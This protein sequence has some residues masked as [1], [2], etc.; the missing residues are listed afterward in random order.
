MR[1]AIFGAGG[2]GCYVGAR[3]LAGGHEVVFIARGRSLEALR[4]RGLRCYSVQGDL[5]LPRVRV[6]DNPHD[7]GAVDA[8][9]LT[10]KL[11]DLDAAAVEFGPLLGPDTLVVPLQN[12]I[13]ASDR[14]TNA[15][16]A[17]CVLKGLVHVVSHLVEPGVVQHSSPFC[18]LVLGELDGRSSPRCEALA[19]TLANCGFD[20]RTS[21]A[22]DAELWRKFTRLAAFS[23]VAC[24]ARADLGTLLAN[25]ALA[26]L[27]SDAM[28]EVAVVARAR[29]IPLPADV[30]QA[31]L[32]EMA[33]YPGKARPSMLEDLEAGRRLEVASLSGAVVRL[34]RLHGV[35]TPIHDVAWRALQ[36][37]ESGRP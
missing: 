9:I 19:R 7:A 25:P 12:G 23:A 36:V 22:I 13:D 6:T 33:G 3:L 15:I 20:A 35:A 4:E 32:D 31:S 1:I 2:V 16:G 14:L 10:V 26:A 24:L 27:L 8:V 21:P 37:H 5:H 29:G 30:V 34:G 17:A 18:R 28:T 11:Y